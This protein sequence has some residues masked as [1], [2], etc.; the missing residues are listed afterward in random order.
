MQVTGNDIRQTTSGLRNQGGSSY[1]IE[2]K[3]PSG[4][5]RFVF[6]KK[7]LHDLVGRS[8]KP[9]AAILSQS[10][11]FA[12]PTSISFSDDETEYSLLSPGWFLFVAGALCWGIVAYMLI[13]LPNKKQFPWVVF[14]PISMGFIALGLWWWK[15]T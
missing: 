5:K 13:K 8:Q 1:Y 15:S 4:E 14:T 12:K 6:C 10:V 11:L 2:I 9:K 3:L 7:P